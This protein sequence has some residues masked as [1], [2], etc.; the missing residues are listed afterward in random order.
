M[1]K[2]K[3]RKPPS[4]LGWGRVPYA[5]ISFSPPSPIFA[6]PGSAGERI[7]SPVSL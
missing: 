2:E 4:R 3:I 7:V 5:L 1:K 6:I